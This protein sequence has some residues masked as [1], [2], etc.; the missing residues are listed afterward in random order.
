MLYSKWLKPT[1]VNFCVLFKLHLY[2]GYIHLLYYTLLLNNSINSK[3]DGSHGINISFPF[4]HKLKAKN[5][6]AF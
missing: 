4:Y 5:R 6:N 1:Y 3:N 2:T